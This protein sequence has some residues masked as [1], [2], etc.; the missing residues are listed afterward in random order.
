MYFFSEM[1]DGFAIAQGDD[2][3]LLATNHFD[4]GFMASPAVAGKAFFLRTKTH[5]YR[6]EQK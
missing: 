2:F 3:E 6:V 5:V 4:A 1:G